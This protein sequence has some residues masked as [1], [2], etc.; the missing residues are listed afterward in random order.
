MIARFEEQYEAHSERLVRLTA[1]QRNR[2]VSVFELAQIASCRKVLAETAWMLQ[3]AAASGFGSCQHCSA[4]I[5]LER[6]VVHPEARY[7]LSCGEESAAV[8]A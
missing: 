4:D 2:K 3:C 8:P 1:K 5:P 7:C 6:L